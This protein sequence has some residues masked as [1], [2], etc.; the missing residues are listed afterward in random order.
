M[1]GRIQQHPPHLRAG[2]VV[3]F[4]SAQFDRTRHRVPTQTIWPLRHGRLAP[5]RT[6]TLSDGRDCPTTSLA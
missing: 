1:A 4:T 2:L 5:T 6:K 3:G